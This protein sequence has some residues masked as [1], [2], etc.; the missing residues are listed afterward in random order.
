M[1]TTKQTTVNRN[2][3]VLLGAAALANPGGLLGRIG[4]AF[5]WLLVLVAGSEL[6]K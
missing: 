4:S 2:L 3:L 6:V 5:L 1:S